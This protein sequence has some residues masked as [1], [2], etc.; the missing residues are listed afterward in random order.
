[1]SSPA[2]AQLLLAGDVFPG[3]LAVR[4]SD[5]VRGLVDSDTLGVIN[6]EGPITRCDDPATDRPGHLRTPP[7]HA[8]VLED[9][10]P[11]VAVLA[12]N[13]IL[14]M[15]AD[16]FEET[17]AILRSRQIQTLGA[18]RDEE[19]AWRPVVVERGG[20]RVGLLAASSREIGTAECGEGKPG[21]AVLEAARLEVE[22]RDLSSRVDAVVVSVHW[23]Q[24][25]FHLPL[26][27]HRNLGRRLIRAG[28]TVV[29]GHHPHV[30]QGFERHESGVI[31]YSLGNLCFSP[32]VR[33]GRLTRLSVENRN[34]AVALV[35]LEPGSVSSLRFH[36]T[37]FDESTGCIELLTGRAAARRDRMLAR[38]SRP[39]GD[40]DYERTYRRYEAR[41]LL[42]RALEWSKPSNWSQLTGE[43]LGAGLESLR[44]V[45][46]VG[47]APTSGSE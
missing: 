34:G 30:L 36:H 39:L 20:L 3:R 43:K 37:R 35:S 21:C 27:K 25:N 46:G 24:T 17:V 47:R 44:R 31:L 26:P 8:T 42:Q 23:G 15:G 29:M 28:A 12:N 13:H 40:D 5:A 4:A 9:I 16:G 2:R 45:V 14:D 6:L 19:E 33:H 38:L 41:R 10:S 7:E 32:Y 18:G 22:I 1:V 11:D